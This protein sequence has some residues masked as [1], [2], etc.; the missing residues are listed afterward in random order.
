MPITRKP[1][2][3]NG[4][5]PAVD[6]NALIH[7]GGSPARTGR[8]MSGDEV[9]VIVR[10]P[11]AALIDV[12]DLVSRRAVKIPRHTWLLEAIHEKVHRERQA[13]AEELIAAKGKK[14]HA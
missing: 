4:H 10:I 13:Q 5:A 2:T 1:K 14:H 12:D 6:V 11:E 3:A 7:K 9:P 8:V